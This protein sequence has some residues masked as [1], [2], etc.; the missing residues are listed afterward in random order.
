[1][2]GATAI[3]C[4]WHRKGARGMHSKCICAPPT[5]VRGVATVWRSSRLAGAGPV[6]ACRW[7]WSGRRVCWSGRRVWLAL[8][9]SSRLAGAGPVVA[10]RSRW[11]RSSRVARAGP[12]VA[13]RSRRRTRR[14]LPR[15]VQLAEPRSTSG[16]P[17]ASVSLQ[18]GRH[19]RVE[20]PS[21]T[22]GSRLPYYP[23][24]HHAP[25][26]PGFCGQLLTQLPVCSLSGCSGSCTRWGYLDSGPTC[27]PVR[28][29]PGGR[30]R[31]RFPSLLDA[32]STARTLPLRRHRCPYRKQHR[33][34]RVVPCS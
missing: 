6:V 26:G 34:H 32:R 17:A 29:F 22:E 12:V 10:R 9:R 11:G 28:V 24:R 15:L 16:G 4:L 20:G 2:W 8:G 14:P 1:M 5:A 3:V 19:L 7:R 33:C 21:S 30:A 27:R 25:E 23:P 13:S 31:E 18:H